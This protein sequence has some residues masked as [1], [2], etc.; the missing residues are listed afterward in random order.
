MYKACYKC[1]MVNTH[2]ESVQQR[3]SGQSIPEG[4]CMRVKL[5]GYRLCY[6]YRML[7]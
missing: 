1:D 5:L 4:P 2:Q 3:T 7:S 6:I